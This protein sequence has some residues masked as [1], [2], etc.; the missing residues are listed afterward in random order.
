M[1]QDRFTSCRRYVATTGRI[2]AVIALAATVAVGGPGSARAD[3]DGVNQG[4]IN[5]ITA[6]VNSPAPSSPVASREENAKRQYLARLFDEVNERRDR[7]LSPRFELMVDGANGAVTDYLRDLLPAMLAYNSCF[8]GS[9]MIGMRAGWDYLEPLGIDG[10]EVGG[11]VLACPDTT[12]Y[13]TPSHLADGWWRSPAH[14]HTLYADNRPVGVACGAE[15]PIDHGKA[16]MTVA[17]ITLIADIGELL[18]LNE[19][20]NP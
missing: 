10:T 20:P 11:E 1:S 19:A 16:Y 3:E 8:H 12:G 6:T 5:L 9:D 2:W 18:A 7:A 13:W 15:G 14:F 4:E 17:C